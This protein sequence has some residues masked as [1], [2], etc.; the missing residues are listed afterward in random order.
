MSGRTEGG[1]RH[2]KTIKQDATGQTFTPSPK[3]RNPHVY[4]LAFI[5]PPQREEK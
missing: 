3:R 5:N 4:F 1:K 2:I